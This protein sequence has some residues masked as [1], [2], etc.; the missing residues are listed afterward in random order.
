MSGLPVV[1][2][3]RRGTKTKTELRDAVCCCVDIAVDNGL[4]ALL[5]LT[6]LTSW[7]FRNGSATMI[8]GRIE[9]TWSARPIWSLIKFYSVGKRGT[10]DQYI[11]TLYF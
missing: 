11:W 9:R 4:E 3:S 8:V 2:C 1:C 7:L 10:I 6:G 5:T